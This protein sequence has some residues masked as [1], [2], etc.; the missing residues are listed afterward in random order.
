M[1]IHKTDTQIQIA[2]VTKEQI[3]VAHIN[4]RMSSHCLI[5][6]LKLRIAH[7]TR[8]DSAMSI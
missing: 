5:Q 2:P 7:S 3:C 8:N 4:R 6:L 1:L